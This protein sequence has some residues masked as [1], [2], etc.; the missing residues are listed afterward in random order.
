[1]GVL[2]SRLSALREQRVLF[3][4]LHTGTVTARRDRLSRFHVGSD[5]N[6][7]DPRAKSYLLDFADEFP[8]HR[9]GGLCFG[10][11]GYLYVAIGDEGGAGDLKN[12]AQDRSRLFGKILRLDVDQNANLAPYYGIRPDNPYAGTRRVPPG[13]LRVRLPQSVARFYDAQ[14]GLD[15]RRG[16]GPAHVGRD[17]RGGEGRQLRLGLSRRPATLRPARQPVVSLCASAGAFQE[18]IH[19]YGH[20]EGS[21]VTGGYVFALAGR[22]DT[23]GAVTSSVISAAGGIWALSLTTASA[24]LLDGLRRTSSRRSDPHR[25]RPGPGGR[26]FADGSPS[27]AVSS[28]SSNEHDQH[29]SLP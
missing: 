6:T 19:V 9:R 1:M 16:C 26:L 13:N 17:R 20:G 25:G 4:L 27:A 28:R 10:G 21:S 12:N 8:N 15:H 23:F 5:P 29:I 7:A 14:V 11:D 3:R 2:V 18:P 22:R 24:M